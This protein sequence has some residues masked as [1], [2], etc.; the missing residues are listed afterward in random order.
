MIY[1]FADL[2]V[3]KDTA[4][5]DG[6]DNQVSLRELVPGQAVTAT[7]RYVIVR[8]KP[9]PESERYHKEHRIT[10][11][12]QIRLTGQILKRKSATSIAELGRDT[13]VGTLLEIKDGRVRVFIEGGSILSESGTEFMAYGN[14][15]YQLENGTRFLDAQ[16]RLI[17]QN[18]IKPFQRVLIKGKDHNYYDGSYGYGG[19]SVASLQVL[20]YGEK[21]LSPTDKDS[22][23]RMT[24]TVLRKQKNAEGAWEYIVSPNEN[25]RERRFQAEYR[26][27]ELDYGFGLS[28][29]FGGAELAP[30]T[31]I[32]F[33]YTGMKYS[34]APGMLI[35]C[36]NLR[37]IENEPQEEETAV[38]VGDFTP[39]DFIDKGIS[40]LLYYGGLVYAPVGWAQNE[41]IRIGELLGSVKRTGL[42]AGRDWKDFDATVLPVGT[43]I[44]K[45]SYAD[46]F[47]AKT[48]NS[49]KMYFGMREG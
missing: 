49:Y 38:I 10:E 1:D 47:A 6:A 22:F 29:V 36:Y 14:Y 28:P 30:G 3:T 16:G 25:R 21:T 2:P 18:V 26:T 5:I 43:E 11:C 48:G 39:E 32:A 45:T 42:K 12:Q 33:N 8:E 20:G 19:S 34:D 44:Y 9:Y 31:R 27:V 37:R 17:D 15:D 4:I 41:Q 13:M 23:H 7:I 24:A 46:M 40:D 35:E